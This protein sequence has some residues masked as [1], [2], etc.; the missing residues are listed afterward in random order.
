MSLNTELVR[1]E[2]AI[3]NKLSTEHN[4]GL[5]AYRDYLKREMKRK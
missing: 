4:F 3:K 2:L 1:V 5:E